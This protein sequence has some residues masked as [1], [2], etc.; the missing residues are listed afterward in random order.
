MLNF[1]FF[2]FLTVRHG[3]I[4]GEPQCSTAAHPLSHNSHYEY[5]FVFF[6]IR[7]K[8]EKDK[9]FFFFLADN[10]L[11]LNCMKGTGTSL[12][13]PIN[14]YGVSLLSLLSN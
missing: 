14:E 8:K 13:T 2:F 9:V 1:F 10:A 5:F 6:S 11:G 4:D 7:F 12:S 3:S